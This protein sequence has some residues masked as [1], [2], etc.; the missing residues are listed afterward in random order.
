MRVGDVDP[1]WRTVQHA[2]N[3][4]MPWWY[5]WLLAAPLALGAIRRVPFRRGRLPLAVTAHVL[6]ALLAGLVHAAL[7]LA[8]Y[9]LTGFPSGS[10]PFW[11]TY[12]AGV[13]FR[14]P[15]G[16]LG[17]GFTF[18]AVLAWDYYHRFRERELAA[19][20]LS[21][22]LA[23]ARLQALRMQLNPHFLF[24]AMNTIAMQVR[25][26]ENGAAVRMIAGLSE[27]LRWVLADSPPQEVPLRRELAFIE[28]YLELERSRFPDRLRFQ[29]QAPPELL[30]ALVPN[31]I[32][33][34]LVENAV[35][36]GIARQVQ[37]GTIRVAG[38]R[39]GED[40]RLTVA[41][42]GAGLR[43]LADDTVTPAT[44]IPLS[45]GGIG[46]RNTT[47]RLE[48]LYGERGRLELESEPGAGFVARVT[49]PFRTG[50]RARPGEAA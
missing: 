13:T 8:I 20:A 49:L 28:R 32:L 4:E 25:R 1:S 45:S 18:G 9:R 6:I 35:K 10:Q 14:I 44:G 7:L 46:L 31:L 30:D 27:L 2:L 15:T 19:A 16:L 33:Q 41:D 40:L 29:I 5:L 22:Q 39:T 43:D 11:E 42:D 34:P 17:Y 23:E 38:E 37:S 50:L 3:K 21:A 24:N 36:H 48:Q 26:R 47:A 12:F